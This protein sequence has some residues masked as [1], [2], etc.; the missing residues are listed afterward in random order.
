MWWHNL[1][2]LGCP[3]VRLKIPDM[4]NWMMQRYFW[5]LPD[6][7]PLLVSLSLPYYRLLATQSI[8]LLPNALWTSS[9][10]DSVLKT[11]HLIPPGNRCVAIARKLL[12]VWRNRAQEC[13]LGTVW[14]FRMLFN[15]R[16]DHFFQLKNC[17]QKWWF[18]WS[19]LNDS[20]TLSGCF[21]NFL[22]KEILIWS[23]AESSHS[24]L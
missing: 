12:G 21:D 5:G 23:D 14:W 15:F 3:A 8:K 9:I 24:L 16:S 19:R 7:N 6:L 10:Q 11:V 2:W 22:L 20:S 4:A 1:L 17:D 13:N 18:N